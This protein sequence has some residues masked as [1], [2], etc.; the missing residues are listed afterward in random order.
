M[1][2]SLFELVA[3]PVRLAIIR[4]LSGSASIPLAEIAEHAGLHANTVRTHMGELEASGA[5]EREHGTSDG[6]GRPQVRYRLRAGWRLPSS[7][8]HGL[9]EL[10]AA[11]IVRL[12]PSVE[13]IQELGRHWGRYLSGRPG[14][15]PVK[16]LPRL[17]ERIG[18]DAEVEGLEI[19]L[20]SCPCPLISP[21]HPELICALAGAAIDGIAETSPRRLRVSSSTHD[22]QRRACTI[23][24][25][26]RSVRGSLGSPG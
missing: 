17:L 14:G 24:L 10:L 20:R 4:E 13:T 6:P 9:S 26:P 8:H 12:D 16:S 15:D 7:D 18:F 5:V 21:E 3:D 25:A 1:A 19:R 22:P 23:R 2:L 11:M